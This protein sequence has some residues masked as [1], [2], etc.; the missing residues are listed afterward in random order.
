MR[1]RHAECTACFSSEHVAGNNGVIRAELAN[2]AG[3]ST[4]LSDLCAELSG[5]ASNPEADLSQLIEL[6]E[7]V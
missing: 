7:L 6:F 3:A 4:P 1:E 2:K 5:R